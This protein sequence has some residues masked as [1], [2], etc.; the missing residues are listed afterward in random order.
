MPRPM[1]SGSISFGLVSIPVKLYSAVTERP[2]RFNQVDA[3]DGARIR[4]KRVNEVTGEEIEYAD[5]AKGYEI[6]KGNYLI[7]TEDELTSLAADATHRLDL[8]CFVDLDEIDPIFYDGAYHVAP[9]KSAKPYALLVQA[10]QASNKVA[11]ARFVMRSKE[12]VA[13]LRPKDD[14]LVM[15]MMVYADELNSKDELGEFEELDDVEVSDRE[16]AMAESLIES[17][18]EPFI[19]E[20]YHDTYRERVLQLIE[21][22][23]AGIEITT[24]APAAR[25]DHVVDLMDALQASLVASKAAR[26]RHPTG[27]PADEEVLDEEVLD[28]DEV[29]EAAPEKKAGTKKAVAKRTPAK[30]APAKPAAKAKRKTA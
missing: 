30:K 1:W 16:L 26:K 20:N 22:K 10:M 8:E 9:S 14:A 11:I 21:Q 3:R 24:E 13:V 29:V 19:P 4:Q 23:S 28:E 7:V 25:N 6:S 2:V 18:S 12:H 5:I 27:I 17:L 15:S